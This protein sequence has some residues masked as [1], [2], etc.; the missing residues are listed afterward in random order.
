MNKLLA[1]ITTVVCTAVAF[2]ARAQASIVPALQAA[3]GRVALSTNMANDKR[4]GRVTAARNKIDRSVGNPEPGSNPTDA[5]T[6]DQPREEKKSTLEKTA[7]SAT[8]T[9]ATGSIGRASANSMSASSSIKSGPGVSAPLAPPTPVPTNVPAKEVSPSGVDSVA[10]LASTN[11]NSTSPVVPPSPIV[12]LTAIY[13]VGAGDVL[14]IRLLNQ[15]QTQQST[16]FTVMAGGLVEYPMAGPP[17]IVDGRTTDEIGALI[18]EELK[19]RAVYDQPQVLVSV[20]EYTSHAVLVSGLAMDPGAK[21]LRREAVP[22]YVIVA[23]AQPK[24]EAG[25]VVVMS[26]ADGLTKSLDL[27]DD[28]GMSVLI[29]PGDVINFVTRPKEFLYI[30]GEINAPG[31]K[32]FHTGITLTQAVLAAGGVSRAGRNMIKVSR[33]N[34]DG[35]LATTEYNLGEIEGG[36]VPDPTL[37]AGDRIEVA[38]SR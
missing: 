7:P 17:L 32:D 28:A 15:P 10:R 36:K 6:G 12:P 22:L 35:L 8:P 18:A 24:P 14:D 34:A 21:I 1:L 2:G 26:F 38:R 37:R 4:T 29:Y 27:D 20:R 19:R 13:R 16:L 9:A 25:R 11:A 23:E 30:G 31:Q 5:V 3:S 33:Q